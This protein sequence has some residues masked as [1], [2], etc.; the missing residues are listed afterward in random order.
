MQFI[1]EYGCDVCTEHLAVEANCIETA[2]TFADGEAWRLRESYEGLHGVLDYNEFC[3]ENNLDS[4]NEDSWGDYIDM[5]RYELHSY[6]EDFD[7]NNEDHISILHDCGG[8]FFA[9]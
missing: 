1:I 4:E 3:E 5:I 8:V 6:A 9:V 2:L 7:E